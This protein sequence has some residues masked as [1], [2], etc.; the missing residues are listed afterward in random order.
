MRTLL[1]IEAGMFFGEQDETAQEQTGAG[2]Q[3]E[4]E[5]DLPGDEPAPQA[6]LRGTARAA[7][8]AAGERI[9]QIG[10][11]KQPGRRETANDGRQQN[12]AAR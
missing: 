9:A 8:S 6:R 4:R 3:D 11:R 1:R 7:A 5:S 12:T 2:Q 10:A